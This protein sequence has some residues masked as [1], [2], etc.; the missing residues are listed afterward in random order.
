MLDE[1]FQWTAEELRA[2]YLHYKNIGLVSTNIT[3][4][5]ERDLHV[6]IAAMD[7]ITN[8]REYL[9]RHRLTSPL[10]DVSRRP[11]IDL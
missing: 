9:Q 1:D 4:D 5:Q 3:D 10:S 11:R 2:A 6:A 7:R 8:L